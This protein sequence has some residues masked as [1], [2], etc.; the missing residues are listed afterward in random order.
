VHFETGEE[1]C[2]MAL[3]RE[4][5]KPERAGP[6]QSRSI[7]CDHALMADALAGRVDC[8]NK[9]G[10]TGRW[11]AEDNLSYGRKKECDALSCCTLQSQPRH[12]AA[13]FDTAKK[14]SPVVAGN[15]EVAF[16]LGLAFNRCPRRGER[17]EFI[18][19]AVADNPVEIED[20]KVIR[21]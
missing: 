4:K 1:L 13:V 19:T 11:R 9:A 5:S 12:L 6:Q 3:D 14:V 2:T 17:E 10:L 7:E 15:H 20:V 8:C 16:N 21:P 18:V